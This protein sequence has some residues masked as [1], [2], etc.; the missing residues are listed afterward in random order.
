MRGMTCGD[1]VF[2]GVRDA[3]YV[4]GPFR[5]VRNEEETSTSDN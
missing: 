5:E 1:Q 3:L 2:V 4:A